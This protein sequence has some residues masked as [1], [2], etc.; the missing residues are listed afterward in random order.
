MLSLDDPRAANL[1][2]ARADLRMIADAELDH[3]ALIDHVSFRGGRGTDGLITAALYA[4]LEPRLTIQLSVYLLSLRHPTLVAR[5][6]MT[7]ATY[8]PGRLIFGVGVGGDD[9]H[10]V[11]VCGVDPSTRGRRMDESLEVLRGLLTGAPVTYHGQH[12][13]LEEGRIL[14]A[15]S[16]PIP[17]VV[18][19]RS[20]AAIRRAGRLGEGWHGVWCSPSRFAAGT[21]LVAEE[22][23][24]VGRGPVAWR[25]GLQIWCGIGASRDEGRRHLETTTQRM[26]RLPFSLFERYAVYGMPA[27]IAEGLYPFVQA[28]CRCFSLMPC[29]ADSPTAIA[30]A[31]EIR[32]LLN[33]A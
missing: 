24:R 21:A 25:H 30:G 11:E 19:G 5:E 1:E 18:G 2:D 13:S 20:D 29:A 14:P 12:I 27:D 22:A 4:A 7:L 6:L 9:R 26:L 3:V 8:A 33:H 32:E 15:P 28:G 17:I 31:Q 23:E 16:E 10:E